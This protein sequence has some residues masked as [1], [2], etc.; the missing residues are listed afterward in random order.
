M[1][2]MSR[3]GLL[4]AA[5]GAGALLIARRAEAQQAVPWS[6]GTE[7]PKTKA[8]PNAADCHHHIYSAKFQVDPNS[9]LRPGDAS[10]ADYRLLQKRIGTTRHVVVQ[11]STYGIYNDGLVESLNAFGPTARGVAVVNAGVSDAELKRLDAAGVRGIRF[12]LANVGG[13]VSMDMLEPLAKRI[14]PLGWHVQF[15]MSADMALA[16]KD[17]LNRL[18]CA[19]VFDHLA[20]LPEPA[21][22]SHP[23]FAMV[24]D[25]MQKG[26]AWVK[27]S[28]AYADTKIGPPTYADSTAVAQAYVKAAP[29]RLVWGSDW[30][31]PSEAVD[32]KPDDA[33]LFDLLAVWAPE[34]AVRNRILVDNPV[35]LYGFV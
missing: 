16:A 24:V 10:V 2:K 35:K 27:L 19:M 18:P 1:P 6:T 5:A 30:P 3:R 22:I 21:G 11:P 14:A 9:T 23:A 32:K 26:K 17:V 20:H 7:L 15:N 28:G 13:A 12:N 31:H 29:E 33:L 8:P 4:H 25:L 34:E